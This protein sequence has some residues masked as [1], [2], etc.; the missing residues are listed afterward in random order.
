MCLEAAGGLRSEA[1]FLSLSLQIG[2]EVVQ[3]T[4]VPFAMLREGV[5][6]SG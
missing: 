1:E 4:A 2:D 3:N 6:L 5:C